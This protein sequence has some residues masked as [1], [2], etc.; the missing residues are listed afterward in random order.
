[1]SP[2]RLIGEQNRVKRCVS[3]RIALVL[4][5]TFAA[6]RLGW[7]QE[8]RWGDPPNRAEIHVHDPTCLRIVADV[9]L[10]RAALGRSAIWRE[11][12][13]VTRYTWRSRI[14]AAK[15]GNAAGAPRAREQFGLHMHRL[16]RRGEWN[17]HNCVWL[18]AVM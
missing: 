1:G 6:F 11:E 18:D 16:A 7:C 4:P 8:F 13:L 12:I 2:G 3:R 14:Q 15:P 17:H 9:E 5:S 10:A